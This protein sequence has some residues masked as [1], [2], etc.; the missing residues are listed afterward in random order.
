MCRSLLYYR[1]HSDSCRQNESAV[2]RVVMEAHRAWWAA[3][4]LAFYFSVA[5]YIEFVLVHSNMAWSRA[6][7][8]EP[9]ST[10]NICWA[11]SLKI[12]HYQ[13]LVHSNEQFRTPYWLPLQLLTI[14]NNGSVRCLCPW[15]VDL[16]GQRKSS[17]EVNYTKRMH[18]TRRLHCYSFYYFPFNNFHNGNTSLVIVL[19]ALWLVERMAYNLTIRFCS[20]IYKHRSESWMSN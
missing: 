7:W 17:E 9:L 19:W 5:E 18:S 16:P 4:A 20:W 15:V 3:A 8:N 6:E 10:K 13:H 11:R 12:L 2:M 14:D 1:T